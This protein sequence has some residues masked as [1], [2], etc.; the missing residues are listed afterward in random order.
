[1]CQVDSQRD[2]EGCGVGHTPREEDS[3]ITRADNDVVT[4]DLLKQK[5]TE[6][7]AMQAQLLSVPRS[8]RKKLKVSVDELDN[9]IKAIH[10][11][12]ALTSEVQK[13]AMALNDSISSSDPDAIATALQSLIKMTV[14]L[15]TIDDVVLFYLISAG[16][17]VVA[18]IKQYPTHCGVVQGGCHALCNLFSGLKHLNN[19]EA[20]AQQLSTVDV[21]DAVIQ[22]MSEQLDNRDVQFYG[23][24]VINILA[25]N[26]N[27]ACMMDIG[28]SD[29]VDSCIA[30]ACFFASARVAVSK[31]RRQHAY[32]TEV[33]QWAD[34][35]MRLL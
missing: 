29:N 30:T 19:G 18:S 25:V 9:Q 27:K 32:D 31:A 16:E 5:N 21:G 11:N 15:T 1:M 28:V 26:M 8:Q 17:G 3:V 14:G 12:F 34:C 2:D 35:A 33:A 6:L 10:N 13:T 22:G 7:H 4:E 24:R 20:L 23:C